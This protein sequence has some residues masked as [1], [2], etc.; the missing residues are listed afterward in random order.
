MRC[1]SEDEAA[2][3]EHAARNIV[4]ASLCLFSHVRRDMKDA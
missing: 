1:C 4:T 3:A 2:K